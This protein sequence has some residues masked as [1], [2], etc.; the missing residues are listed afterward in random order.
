MKKDFARNHGFTLV[1][2]LVSIAILTIILVMATQI[3]ISARDTTTT[4]QRFIDAERQ[5][6]RIFGQLQRD[7]DSMLVRN[8]IPWQFEKE[9]GDDRLIFLT[10]RD[11][12]SIDGGIAADRGISIAHYRV[13]EGALERG[14]IGLSFPEKGGGGDLA[15]GFLVLQDDIDFPEPPVENFQVLSE[16]VLKFEIGFISRNEAGAGASFVLPN[17][18]TDLRAITVTLVTIDPKSGRLL[19]PEQMSAVS[20]LFPEPANGVRAGEEWSTVVEDILNQGRGLPQAAL[21]QVR[22]SH[23]IYPIKS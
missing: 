23:R 14:S 15:S 6:G 17:K 21:K 19:S 4:S 3:T 20:A 16:G 18:L 10:Q 1:E 9:E 12:Y 8:D 5:V 22:V 13:V 7:F 2:V 11:G